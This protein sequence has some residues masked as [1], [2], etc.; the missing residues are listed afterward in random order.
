L[1]LSLG[2]DKGVAIKRTKLKDFSKRQ[3]IGNFRTEERAFE[4]AVR[5]TKPQAIHLIIE[6]QFP[7]SSQSD[8][9]V[10][11]I[12]TSDGRVDETTGMISW[13]LN[14]AA[15]SESKVTMH[16]SVKFPKSMT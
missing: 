13:D 5:N 1:E 9:E 14:V 11:Q 2:V 4:I 15:K 16:Y 12:K 3:F 10:K 8:I 7:V 6:D